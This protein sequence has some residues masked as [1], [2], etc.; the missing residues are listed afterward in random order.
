MLAATP[1]GCGS[2]RRDLLRQKSKSRG[3]A[4]ARLQPVPGLRSA[5]AGCRP[6]RDSTLAACYRACTHLARAGRMTVTIGRRELLVALG[7]AATAWP[8]AARAHQQSMPVIGFVSSR[9][10]DGSARHASAFSK[11]LTE[12]GYVEGQNV[13]VEY[14]W[15][16]GQHDRLPSL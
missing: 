5:R 1:G 2:R 3:L 7:G 12:T 8:L 4:L 11:G 10:L 6:V 16:S 13:T 9:S 15:L 14:R